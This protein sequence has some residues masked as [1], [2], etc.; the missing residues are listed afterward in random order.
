MPTLE[1]IFDANI[2]RK[3]SEENKRIIGTGISPSVKN[4]ILEEACKG[5]TEYIFAYILYDEDIKILNELGFKVKIIDNVV[6]PGNL[7]TE[8]SW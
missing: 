8:V 7:V 5:K 1:P 6:I 2:C 4:C 3:I